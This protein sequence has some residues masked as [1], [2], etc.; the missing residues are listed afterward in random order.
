MKRT[1]A[2]LLTAVLMLSTGLTAFASENTNTVQAVSQQTGQVD[3]V[4][5]SA[6]VLMNPVAFAVEKP[7][8]RDRYRR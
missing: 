7:D 2:F 3:V 4:I 8:R 1:L 5:G 6:L